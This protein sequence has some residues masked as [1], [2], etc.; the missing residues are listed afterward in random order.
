M[1][2]LWPFILPLFFLFFL[3]IYCWMSCT[4]PLKY[5]FTKSEARLFLVIKQKI[6]YYCYISYTVCYIDFMCHI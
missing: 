1:Y 6:R 5:T 4:I 3:L 2:T